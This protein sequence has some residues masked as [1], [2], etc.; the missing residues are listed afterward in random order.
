MDE[1]H[2]ICT[3]SFNRALKDPS[4]ESLSEVFELLKSHFAH[5]EELI[6]KYAITPEQAA[7]PFSALV[8]HRKDHI[9]ILSIAAVE[10][11]RVANLH[12]AGAGGCDVVGGRKV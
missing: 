9:R 8:T 12:N 11:Q 2:Q 1:E 3:D 7:S 4:F 10:L 6:G 5:E